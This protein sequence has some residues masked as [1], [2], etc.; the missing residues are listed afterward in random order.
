M[1]DIRSLE[2]KEIENIAEALGERAYRGRQIFSWLS[3]GASSFDEMT[4]LPLAFREKLAGE[5][6]ISGLEVLREQR[7]KDG[8]RKFLFGLDDGN[9][10]ETVYM[11]YR[12]GRSICV[13]SQAGCRMGCSFCASGN[14]GLVRGLKSGEIAGQIIETQ[15]RCCK[16]GERIGH[17]VV[18][19]T[20]EPFDNYDN[21]FKFVRI[22]NSSRGLDIGMRN[23]TISTCGIVPYI[24][25]MAED[26]PQVNLAVSLHAPPDEIR[27]RIMPVANAY[28]MDELIAACRA[29]IEKTSR[30]VTFEY[31]VTRGVNDSEENIHDLA[32]LLSGM[33]CHVNL[34]PLNSIEKSGL[35]S[36]GRKRAEEI[37]DMLE[38]RGIPAT[39]RRTLGSD[40]DASCGQLR[41]SHSRGS[42]S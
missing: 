14:D 21:V 25:R 23:I 42:D 34:I 4:D 10:I 24:Y 33:L 41:L 11:E 8:T 20:G 27:K 28:P 13:S 7:S 32:D 22:I 9:A 19:G 5:C 15:K 35:Q 40:I 26:M 38:N 6:V 1:I 18:M 2:S 12:Y 17:V 39:V 37:R 31:A 16:D 29:Y 30:R 36:P 3:R